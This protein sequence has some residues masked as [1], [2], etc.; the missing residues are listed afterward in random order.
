[1]MGRLLRR[2]LNL[3]NRTDLAWRV[4]PTTFSRELEYKQLTCLRLER[5]A[6]GNRPPGRRAPS[7]RI[8]GHTTGCQVNILRNTF[9]REQA[10]RV[11]QIAMLAMSLSLGIL[12]T[13]DAMSQ[14]QP[15]NV[16]V[17]ESVAPA[18]V[19]PTTAATPPLDAQADSASSLAPSPSE[20]ESNPELAPPDVPAPLST[21]EQKEYFELLT[22]F[23]DTLDQ[24]ER[25]YVKEVSRRELME[26][27][28]QGV[29]SKLDE[30]SD[31]IPPSQL[32]SFRTG[33][34]S[35][36]GGIGIR[37]GLMDGKL[38]VITPIVNTPAYRADIRAGDQILKLARLRPTVCRWTMPFNE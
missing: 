16:A 10:S 25:N 30:Y 1:M 19:P 11:I 18:T 32:D 31:F 38:T 13:R 12:T 23:A 24:V 8:S 17:E 5:I 4:A 34:E 28:I 26:A 9:R 35:E 7:L 6:S 20:L 3:A 14:E 22:L 2:C 27:A 37:V 21:A 15:S 33:V 29:L 36:F